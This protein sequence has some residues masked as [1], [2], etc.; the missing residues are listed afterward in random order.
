MG[1]ISASALVLGSIIS[2][3]LID[4]ITW[5]SVFYIN[6]PIFLYSIVSSIK[7]NAETESRVNLVDSK[8]GVKSA[9]FSAFLML[10][11]L[12]T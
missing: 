12:L 11:M 9:I 6:I 7:F 2:G 5:R 1:G 3:L 4:N 8:R 10:T